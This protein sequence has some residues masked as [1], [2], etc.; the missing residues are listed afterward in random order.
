M[1]A[2]IDAARRDLRQ[3]LRGIVRMPVLATVVI[4]SLGVGIGLESV[5]FS[6]IQGVVLRPLPGVDDATSYHLV[7]P[8]TDTGLFPVTSWLEYRELAGQPRCF[9]RAPRF[10]SAHRFVCS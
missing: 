4:V 6:W 1:V 8:R 5:V 2:W 7:E 3:S 10:R 9:R